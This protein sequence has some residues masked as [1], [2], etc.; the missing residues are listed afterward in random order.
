[1]DLFYEPSFE[2]KTNDSA[3]HRHRPLTKRAI[4]TTE[5]APMMKLMVEGE[6]EKKRKRILQAAEDYVG[7]IK[8]FVRCNLTNPE[9]RE[10]Y[11]HR[12]GEKGT[13]YYLAGLKKKKT[14]E[15]ASYVTTCADGT[16]K[17]TLVEAQMLSSMQLPAIA[18]PCATVKQIIE[19][20][21]AAATPAT[22]TKLDSVDEVKEDC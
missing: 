19:A 11:V 16:L 7:I 22:E 10:G 12:D 14:A 1:M 21:V 9:P 15:E 13:G 20:A 18:L 8:P 5:S 6:E 2:I 17:M 4:N 3:L